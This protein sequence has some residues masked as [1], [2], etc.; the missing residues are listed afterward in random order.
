LNTKIK[1]TE[2]T[3]ED[4]AAFFLGAPEISVFVACCVTI[5]ELRGLEQSL[6]RGET[7]RDLFA[8]KSAALLARLGE[9]AD[10]TQRF[11]VVY[12]VMAPGRFSPFFWR[13]F[14]WWDDYLKKL[15][16]SRVAQLEQCA[17]EKGSLIDELRPQGHW[18]N[19]R[20]TP[21][22]HESAEKVGSPAKA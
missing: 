8:E 4:V 7:Q 11:D 17:R 12:P 5:N 13:W 9:A 10:A 14:N 18:I 2:S 21:A 6:E 15:R 19:Y 20:C 22:V 3:P 16:P 1:P